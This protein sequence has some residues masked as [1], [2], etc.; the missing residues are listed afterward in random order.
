VAGSKPRRYL[1]SQLVTLRWGAESHI[2]NLEEICRNEAMLEADAC[3]PV[4]TQVTLVAEKSRFHG[5]VSSAEEH[6]FGWRIRVELSPLTPW[7]LDAF[8]PE[9][10]L[11]PSDLK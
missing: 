10:L 8:A 9:H 2:V 3:V 11:D 6:E 1:C 4:S 7:S 5:I